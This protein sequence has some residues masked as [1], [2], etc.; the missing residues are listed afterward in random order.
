MTLECPSCVVCRASLC[1]NNNFLVNTLVIT[2]LVQSSSNLLRMIILIISRTS[3]NMGGVRSK[4]RSLG[5]IYMYV[6]YCYHSR[7]HNARN[8]YLDN[9]LEKFEYGWGWVKK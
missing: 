2:I 6:K 3:L 4:S 5:Q 1:V 9:I 8:V 7:S